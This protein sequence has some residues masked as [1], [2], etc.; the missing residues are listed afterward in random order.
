MT[1]RCFSEDQCS[2]DLP[3]DRIPCGDRLNACKDFHAS[4]LEFEFLGS[5]LENLLLTSI[6]GYSGLHSQSLEV[7]SHPCCL[8]V[9]HTPEMWAWP[10]IFSIPKALYVQVLFGWFLLKC[11]FL[12]PFQEIQLE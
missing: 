11:R 3:N 12:A 2:P 4:P 10:L 1:N 7:P 6:L 9:N 8:H 5:S